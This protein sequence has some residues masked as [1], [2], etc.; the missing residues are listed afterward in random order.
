M[1]SKFS[2][3]PSVSQHQHLLFVRFEEADTF[4][5]TRAIPQKVDFKEKDVQAVWTLFS[6]TD[7]KKPPSLPFVP[8]HRITAFLED[9][10]HDW[11]ITPKGMFRFFSRVVDRDCWVLIQLKEGSK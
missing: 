11:A 1:P 7:E 4:A 8:Q 9:K 6:Y 2:S 5:G 3:S 10:L